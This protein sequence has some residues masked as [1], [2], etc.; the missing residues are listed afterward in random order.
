M[1]SPINGTV[2]NLVTLYATR[3][4]H[5]FSKTMLNM[6]L[7]RNE[8][9]DGEMTDILWCKSQTEDSIISSEMTSVEETHCN[10][11]N[12]IV[13]FLKQAI[14]RFLF[15][16]LQ[17]S[18]LT[19]LHHHITPS[20]SPSPTAHYML[21]VDF[22]Y[23]IIYYSSTPF[24]HPHLGSCSLT[25]TIATTFLLLPTFTTTSSTTCLTLLRVKSSEIIQTTTIR[26]L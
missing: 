11:Y 17:I 6:L 21:L 3:D 1:T 9:R 25:R 22:L 8:A 26:L 15:S 16:L 5:Q 18:V 2:C 12:Y 4:G 7:L 24:L 13:R 14:R 10:Q 19:L 20:S 23:P